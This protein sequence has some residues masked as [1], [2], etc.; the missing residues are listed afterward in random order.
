METTGRLGESV[1]DS[2]ISAFGSMPAVVAEAP[3]RV[4]LIGEHTDYNEGWVLPAALTLGTAVAARIRSDRQLRV[5][6]RRLDAEDHAD[7]DNL[8]PADGPEW[9][10][11]VRGMAQMLVDFGCEVPGAEVLI[12][13]DLPLGAGLSSSASLE[14]AVGAAL[15][16]LAGDRI[17]PKKMAQLGRRAENEIVGVQTGLMDQLAVALGRKGHALLI[18]CR[19]LDAATVPVPGEAR[20]LIL[21]TGA[22]RSVGD[23]D[24]N[25]RREECHAALSELRKARPELVSLRDVTPELLEKDGWRL[26]QTELRRARHVVTENA[27]V[28]RAA[29]ALYGDDLAVLGELMNSSHASL[30]DD[31]EVS[32]PAL[33]A[34]VEAALSWPGVYGARLT[35]AGFGGCVVALVAAQF[36]PAAL[37]QIPE[38][39]K[40]RTGSAGRAYLCAPGDGASVTRLD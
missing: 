32:S 14:L 37:I 36:A 38:V 30:R 19:S 39:Y 13:G 20:I 21:D 34:M 25:R 7:L 11:Y 27:R 8:R 5:I 31:F 6:S 18:D 4:N 33:D 3:G 15:A 17:D 9:T 29:D 2:F 1:A 24:Y 26:G 10:R 28:R 23:S 22:R 35:G 16:D 12:D 40:S